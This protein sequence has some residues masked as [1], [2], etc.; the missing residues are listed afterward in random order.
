MRDAISNNADIELECVEIPAHKL[1]IQA[2]WD[3]FVSALGAEIYFLSDW[4]SAWWDHYGKTF[5][6]SRHPV[7]Y[8]LRNGSEIVGVLPFC[9]ETLW[10]GPIPVRVARLAGVDP[11]FAV[12]ELPIA[13]G[14]EN[15]VLGAVI[16]HLTD[17]LKCSVVSLS[18]LSER[19]GQL[20]NLRALNGRGLS[21]LRDISTRGHTLMTLPDTFD[22]FMASLSKS[23]RREV[24]RDI[25]RLT[26][27]GEVLRTVSSTPETVDAMMDRF[28]ALHTRQ[29]EAAGKGGHF[30]DWPVAAAFYRSLMQGLSPKGHAAIDE[31]WRDETLLSSQLRY[32]LNGKVL[33][34]L[35]AR[36]VDAEFAKA[37]LGRV[38]LVT[39]VEE[40]I[41]QDAHLIEAGAGEY[42][43]KLSYGG[44]LVPLYNIVL[45][46][47]RA[48]ARLRA[49][50]LLLWA[51]ALH[52]FYYRVWFL[53]VRPRLGIRP[54]SLWS[55][56]IRMQL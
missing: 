35:N 1:S 46:P 24:R 53:K 56:W 16:E 20:E 48:S 26:P 39:R 5:A 43:Y 32:T 22:A 21:V 29:W 2:S 11:N 9:V 45:A 34:W 23:R 28:I 42:E 33:W 13:A 41:D 15:T 49:R 40:L 18:P 17:H 31:Q 14:Y 44:D 50:L 47:D 3:S 7:S 6:A 52:F 37:G 51:D 38:G 19:A 54:N 12:M 27:A 8:I 4:Q 30:S 25:K 55:S 10:A 36:E